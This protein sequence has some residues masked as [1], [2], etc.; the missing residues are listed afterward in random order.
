LPLRNRNGLKDFPSDSGT[1][2]TASCATFRAE[3][4]VARCCL[5]YGSDDSEYRFAAR[6][7]DSLQSL[8]RDGVVL[9]VGTFSKVLFP[10]VRT[11]FIGSPE[12]I[13]S[14]LVAA[15]QLTDWHGPLLTQ[16]TLARFIQEGHLARY[17]RKMRR[18]YAERRQRLLD[19]LEAELSDWLQT[20]PS[21]AGLH[22]AGKMR[23]GLSA[24]VIARSGA[25]L[26][27]KVQPFGQDGL[28]LGYGAIEASQIEE[29]IRRLTRAIKKVA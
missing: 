15:R 1:H 16:A 13:R 27:V 22:I 23:A 14:A 11:G 28:A 7:L 2:G 20:W 10:G 4:N 9:Y 24:D 25:R 5:W 18:V 8:D 6:P 19:C 3:R 12:P 29:G 17:I 26:G 21:T